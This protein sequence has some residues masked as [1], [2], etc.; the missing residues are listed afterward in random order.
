MT[1]QVVG[2]LHQATRMK[3]VRFSEFFRDH[4]K[5]RTGECSISALQSALTRLNLRLN[6]DDLRSLLTLYTNTTSGRFR[7]RKLVHD[8]STTEK[9]VV[10]MD[11]KSVRNLHEG[12]TTQNHRQ[13]T[14]TKGQVSALSLLQS[15]VY[16]R[17]VDFRSFFLDFD[18]LRKGR[19][20][21]SNLRCV[22]TLLNFEVTEEEISEIVSLYGTNEAPKN[23][24]YDRLCID[25]ELALSCPRLEGDP[26]GTPPPKF[27]LLAT[28]EGKKAVLTSSEMSCI[29]DIEET[30]RRRVSQRGLNLLGHFRAFDGH[31][32]LVITG[33][34]FGRVLATLGFDMHASDV[35]LL[36]KK[37]CMNGSNSRFAYREFC[38]SICA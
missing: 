32:R 31:G 22:L 36:C 12:P 6:D 21:E 14:W 4:D 11:E 38:D 33:N 37:Y 8:I 34:Q 35:D 16:E 3:R 2:R 25:V 7:Y 29:A 19:V 9:G 1:Y 5:L 30:V 20:S 28:K 23:I 13:H 26:L 15:Q 24:N 17:R 27:D 10:T 18:P